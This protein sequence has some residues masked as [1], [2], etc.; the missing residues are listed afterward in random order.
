M[1]SLAGIRIAPSRIGWSAALAVL[2]ALTAAGSA[3][4]AQTNGPPVGS[5]VRVANTDGQRLNLRAGP[6]V[7]QAVLARLP[8]GTILT[9]TGA[10]QTA[11]GIRWV[12]VRDASGQAGWVAG[13]Y[14]V[15]ASTPTP[16]ATTATPTASPAATP[17]PSGTPLAASPAGPKGAPLQVEAKLKFP[18]TDGRS[19][20]ITVWVTR[21]G[22]PVPG[23]I[24]TIEA[25]DGDQELYRELDPTDEN[26]RTRRE[27][28]IRHEKG[29]VELQVEAIAPDGGE[30]RTTVSYFR[31]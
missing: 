18:E 15:V 27:F 20:E 13:Q 9:V 10:A 6:S 17:T 30:G 7:D 23:A 16:T 12:P 11:G 1:R 31:R 5:T 14:L 19:Q 4:L 8:E 29:T 26:G 28:D 3:A 25:R 2:L 22:A 24:V 21:D